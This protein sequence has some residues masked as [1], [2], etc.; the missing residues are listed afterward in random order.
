MP[1]QHAKGPGLVGSYASA[2]GY[3]TPATPA[4]PLTYAAVTVNTGTALTVNTGVAFE[5]RTP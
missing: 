1:Q 5:A 2:P 4:A 3:R